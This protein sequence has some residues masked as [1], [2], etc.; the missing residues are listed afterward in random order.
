MVAL[1][2]LGG[3]VEMYPLAVAGGGEHAA[4]RV[5]QEHR[6]RL[7]FEPERMRGGDRRVSA[8]IDFHFRREPAQRETVVATKEKCG[9]GE[10]HLRR[11]ALHPLR[12]PHLVEDADGGR[13]SAKRLAGEGVNGVDAQSDSRDFR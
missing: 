11:D 2:T 12:R 13:I 5:K 3:E 8:E 4:L 9:L 7:A 10:I 6:G 1:C